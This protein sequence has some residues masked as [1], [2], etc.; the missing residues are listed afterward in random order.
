MQTTPSHSVLFFS[1]RFMLIL[2]CTLFFLAS[3][4]DGTDTHYGQPRTSQ[5]DG[6]TITSP[7]HSKSDSNGTNTDEKLRTQLT[8]VDQIMKSMTLDEKLGQLIMVEFFGSGY[9]NTELPYMVNQQHVGGYLYQVVNG[10]FNA[11]SN[12]VDGSRQVT[13]QANNDAKIPLL[14]AIDQEG[15]Q[16]NKLGDAFYGPSPSAASMVAQGDPKFAFNQGTQTAK[17]MQSVGINV[18]LAPVVDVGPTSNLLEDRQFSDNPKTVATYAGAFVD[19]LQ[20]NGIIGTLKHFPGLGSLSKGDSNDPHLSLPVVNKS[21]AELESTDFAPYKTLIQQNHPAMIMSTDVI[22]TAIDPN[23]PAELSSKAIDGVLRKEL[24]YNGVVITDGL[25]MD[26]VQK[27]VGSVGGKDFAK[28][29]LLS[30]LAGNDMVEG[31]FTASQV[32]STIQNF[33][34]AIQ[35]GQL[36]EARVDQSVQRILL[37]KVQY[38]I[39]K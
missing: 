23:V 9:A 31:A 12:T 1:R 30:I 24:G 35:Q 2:C 4:A 5:V 37:M 38:G 13:V 11:P 16:V 34:N 29:S 20:T 18:D 15:G 36:T 25:Y 21:M 10:N 22:T 27:Y 39:I 26:G 19:G 6:A 32:A 14:I 8:K 33:K 28:P 7:A 3:C 17:E